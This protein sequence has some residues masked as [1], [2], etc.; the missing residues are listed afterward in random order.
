MDLASSSVQVAGLV[1]SSLSVSPLRQNTVTDQSGFHGIFQLTFFA[2][3][4]YFGLQAIVVLRSVHQHVQYPCVGNKMAVLE[5]KNIET[6]A[7]LKT[8]TNTLCGVGDGHDLLSP[9]THLRKERQCR[10]RRTQSVNCPP[11]FSSLLVTR[12]AIAHAHISRDI[13]GLYL[14]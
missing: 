1:G 8:C 11:T 14:E 9:P 7:V 10:K 2:P 12:Q 13:G 3:S 4:L 5:K 6:M